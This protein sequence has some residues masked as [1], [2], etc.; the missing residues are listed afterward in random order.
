MKQKYQKAF[1]TL[2]AMGVPVYEHVD[3]NGNFSISAEEAGSDNW[4]SYY[5][6]VPGWVFGVHPDLDAALRKHGMHAQWEN[7]ARLC[8]HMI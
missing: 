1:D 5:G 2:K 6:S 4:V 3:D 7:P 8:V